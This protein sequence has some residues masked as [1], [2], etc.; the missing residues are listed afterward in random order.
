MIGDRIHVLG[1]SASGKSA[2]GKRLALILDADFV[3][4]DALNWLPD[5]V[6]LNATDPDELTRRFETATDSDKWVVAG[7]YTKFAKRT[8][9][10][11]L[12]TVIWLDLP[13][14]ILLWRVVRR[15]WRRWRSRELLWGT[16][17]E[18]FWPQ[19]AF[20]RGDDS[21]IYWIISAQRGKRESMLMAMA[22]PRWR[23]IRFIRLTSTREIETFVTTVEKAMSDV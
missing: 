19:L 6:G 17:V 18:R 5:W 13:V 8:F 7:S 1:N 22:D 20:W 4:L 21:L 12:D 3:E 10:S 9:W 11:R 14:P 2:L 23:K 15:S 16:N